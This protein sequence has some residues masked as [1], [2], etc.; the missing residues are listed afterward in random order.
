ML[1]LLLCPGMP[2][3]VFACP[4]VVNDFDLTTAGAGV[5]PNL[6]EA[7]LVIRGAI[8]GAAV[9]AT[10]IVLERL[11]PGTFANVSA[12][13]S[14]DT[15]TRGLL[16][17]FSTGCPIRS[18][19]AFDMRGTIDGL[20]CVAGIGR[21]LNTGLPFKLSLPELPPLSVDGLVAFDGA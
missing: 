12:W 16:T 7:A 3:N 13:R 1:S 19:A 15:G 8:V 9:D 14:F 20:P 6:K 4:S 11:W 17:T 18:A 21:A 5:C 10:A 2:S